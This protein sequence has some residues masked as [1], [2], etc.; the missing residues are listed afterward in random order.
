MS[1]TR[2]KTKFAEIR[3]GIFV[4]ASFVILALAV[5]YISAGSSIF[6]PTFKAVTYLPNVGG[7]KPGAPVQLAGVE[8]GDVEQVRILPRELE[9][10]NEQNSKIEARSKSVR[11][12]IQARKEKQVLYQAAEKELSIRNEELKKSGAVN[13]QEYKKLQTSLADMR[14]NLENNLNLIANLEDEE[15]RLRQS[16][17]NVEV[18]LKVDQRYRS[19]IRKDSEVGVGSIGLLG[20]KYIDITLGRSEA[21][22]ENDERGY[23]VIT[24]K[25]QADF[26]ELITGIDDVVGNFGVL[27]QRFRNLTNK[28]EEGTVAQFIGDRSFYDNLNTTLTEASTTLKTATELIRE[29]KEGRGTMGR[30]ISD[31]KLYSEVNTATSQTNQLLQKVNSGEGSLGKFIA[32]PGVYDKADAV[33]SSADTI[34]SRISKGEGTLGKLSKDEALYE[35]TK[36]AMEKFANLVD[37]VEQGK[38]TLGKLVKDKTLYDNLTQASSEVVKLLYD[39]RQDPK[40]YLTIRFRVF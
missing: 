15:I 34:A 7:L 6:A 12:E 8:V 5:I 10:K 11:D 19:W 38:G 20:D 39:F 27:S 16:I 33:L 23:A 1:P 40:K 25:M 18:V 21:P 13:S 32:N 31:D 35:R 26:R 28:I 37:E 9:P 36:L 2:K 17:Q 24:G 30:L 4:V 3:V 22:S 14:V 29:I